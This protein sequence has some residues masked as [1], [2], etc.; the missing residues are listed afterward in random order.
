M[1]DLLGAML[2]CNKDPVVDKLIHGLISK[3]LQC[4]ADMVESNKRA[5]S[6]VI[7]GLEESNLEQLPSVR[8][9]ELEKQV[10]NVLD[11]LG[12]ECRPVEVYRM[13]KPND[14]RPRLVKLVLPSTSHWKQALSNSFRLRHTPGFSNVFV[15][16]SLTEPER[17]KEFE[18][19]QECR[20]R[21]NQ[22]GKRVWVVF[23]GEIRRID[24]LPK[25]GASGN[26]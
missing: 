16:K 17:R 12:V 18:L 1:N 9:K 7:T 20:E 26:D 3:L 5:R 19:R 10:T 4:F 8:Q 6:L 11:C 22:L 2:D 14:G 24:D 23:R 25:R 15:R 21:N 13:G